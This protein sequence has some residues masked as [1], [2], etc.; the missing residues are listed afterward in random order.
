[1]R[2]LV[3]TP[4]EVVLDVSGVRHVRA[5]DATG[6]FGIQPGH[7]DFITALTTSVITWSDKEEKRSHVVVQGGV[8]AVRDGS[9][10][11]VAT[12]DAVGEEELR[13]LGPAVLA[14][15]REERQAEE[16]SR[17]S[18][19]RLQLAAIKQLQRYLQSGRQDMPQGSLPSLQGSAF[20]EGA[21][22]EGSR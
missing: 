3:T 16:S 8:L 12:R 7:A 22:G 20:G 1:M 15:F 4:M 10:V 11:E 19:A 18:S 5:E 2:L 21:E 6:A 9:L 13:A 14:R 17:T